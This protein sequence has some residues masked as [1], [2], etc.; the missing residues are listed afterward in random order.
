MTNENLQL[1]YPLSISSTMGTIERQV[2]AQV[3]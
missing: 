3:N 1:F 2:P